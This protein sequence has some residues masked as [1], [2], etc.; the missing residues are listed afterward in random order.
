MSSGTLNSTIPYHTWFFLVCLNPERPREEIADQIWE[1]WS[2]FCLFVVFAVTKI[3][4]KTAVK[5]DEM[6]I[7]GA[8]HWLVY[9]CSTH[10]QRRMCHV[11]PGNLILYYVTYSTGRQ[12]AKPGFEAT[13]GL[14]GC[15]NRP[16]PFPGRMSYKATKERTRSSF[17]FTS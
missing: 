1:I 17:C 3:A 13:C 2:C 7:A 10:F 4:D 14:L 16:A 5:S 6:G 9:W 8:A 11:C 15:K 12:M